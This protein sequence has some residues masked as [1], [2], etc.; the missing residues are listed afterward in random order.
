MASCNWLSVAMIFG[1]GT[2]WRGRLIRA[3][4]SSSLV[5]TSMPRHRTDTR[6]QPPSAITRLGYFHEF[7]M[8]RLGAC[9]RE[10]LVEPA[11]AGRAGGVERGWLTGVIG[12]SKW[13]R[14]LD[15][16]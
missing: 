7:Q 14:E 3:A 10:A 4:R 5:P 15:C 12:A 2:S 9:W 6:T 11:H 1:A 8:P 13:L 16:A